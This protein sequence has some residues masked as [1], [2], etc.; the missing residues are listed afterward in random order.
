MGS[1]PSDCILLI[2]LSAVVQQNSITVSSQPGDCI[3]Y[4]ILFMLSN[5]KLKVGSQAW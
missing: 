2:I 1:Q 5:R 4:I 3:S